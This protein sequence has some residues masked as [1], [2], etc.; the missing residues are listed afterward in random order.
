MTY[1]SLVLLTVAVAAAV[2]LF[3]P[4]KCD[5]ELVKA[6]TSPDGKH[7]IT[8]LRRGCGATTG[9]TTEAVLQPAGT[10]IASGQEYV[11]AADTNHG[12]AEADPYG[13]VNI[14][15]IWLDSNTVNISYESNS[16]VFKA[17]RQYN[18]VE[19]HYFSFQH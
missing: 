9:F 14:D 6:I 13:A 15:V 2:Q 12:A 19:F 1:A 10:F 11:F 16:R 17:V 8:V 3:A 7:Q 5:N 4:V 18:G